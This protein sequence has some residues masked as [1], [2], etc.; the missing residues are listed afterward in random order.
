LILLHNKNVTKWKF[1]FQAWSATCIP[2]QNA[3]G[4]T[5]NGSTLRARSAGSDFCLVE[6]NQLPPANSGITFAGWSRNTTGIQNTTIIHH[7]RG[8]VMKISR[9]NGTPVFNTFQGAQCWRLS[10]DEGAT[11]G[12]SSGSPYFDQNNRIIAQHFGINDGNLPVCDRV[13]KFGGRFDVSWTGDGTNASRLSNWLDPNNTNAMTTD[14]RGIGIIGPP[15]V[16]GTETYSFAGVTSWTSSNPTG[17]SI[18]AA[19][20]ATRQNNFNGQV[21]ITAS[22]ASACGSIPFTQTIW[23]GR[24]ILTGGTASTSNVQLDNTIS[25][26]LYWNN[27]AVGNHTLSVY[28]YGKTSTGANTTVNFSNVRRTPTMTFPAV[29][30]SSSAAVANYNWF[31]QQQGD[32]YT[33]NV[34]TSNSC[35]NFVLTRIAVVTTTSDSNPARMRPTK[36]EVPVV[37]SELLVQ[38]PI[39]FPNPSSESFI[40]GLSTDDDGMAIDGTL[41]SDAELILY[42]SL[43]QEVFRGNTN[44]SLITIP[45][46]GLQAGAYYL[47]INHGLGV[48][49]KKVIIN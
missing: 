33:I 11:E 17:L 32:H 29:T 3:N 2:T 14:T 20:T 6:L 42:N 46:T 36:E 25:P 23:V 22:V 48:V 19:G 37:P 10:L 31:V 49:R 47:Q 5:F 13:N 44:K 1:T 15:L 24:P 30:S 8:D 40:V 16:C 4:T 7:P 38:S 45:T 35:D 26:D 27:V 12:G 28:R 9:D 21:T 39:I 41:K 43:Q 18:N 34:S